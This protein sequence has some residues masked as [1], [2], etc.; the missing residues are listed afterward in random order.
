MRQEIIH[1]MPVRLRGFV[2]QSLRKE[3]D[4]EEIRI[5]IGQPLEIH[6]KDKSVWLTEKVTASDIEE[7][8]TFISRYSMY[9]YEEEIRQGYLTIEGGCRIGFAGQARL[10]NGQVERMT[11]IRFLNIRI[12]GEKKGCAKKLLPWI[13][14]NGDF[15]NTLLVSKPGVGKTTY[16]RDCIRLLSNGNTEGNGRKICVID[17]RSEI[18]ACHLGI[19]QNDLGRRTDVLDGSPKQEG[20]RMALRSMSPEIIAVDELGGR[21]DAKAVEEMILCG[22]GIL[23]S[24]HGDTME[25]LTNMAEIG[26][27]YQKKLIQRYVFLKKREDGER[28]FYVYDKDGRQLC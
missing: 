12:A 16:L 1:I 21:A 8:L 19:P 20:M 5:R 28:I 23:G 6:C 14:P 13:C 4:A 7:M 9:A 15:V 25:H 27:M 2:E 3:S 26:Q 17:E 11:N 18:A 10:K 24:V 22:C